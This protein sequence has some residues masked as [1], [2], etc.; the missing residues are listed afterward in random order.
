MNPMRLTISLI[1]FLCSLTLSFAAQA[2]DDVGGSV[3]FATFNIA[4]GLESEGE[5]YRRL[6]SGQDE[7]LK[8]VA[9]VIQQVRPD[10]LL[11]NEFDWYEL[12]SAVLF[13]NNYLS[14]PQFGNQAINYDHALNGAVN[15][16][17]DSGLDLNGNGTLGQPEDAWG[18]GK[19]SGQYG[20]M[21]LSRFPLQLQRS[22]RLFKWSD[23][24]DALIPLN[25]DGSNYYPEAIWKQLRLSSKNHW[26]IE[27]KI[28][29]Q[30]VHFLASHPTPPVFDG[31]EDRN[32]T[33]NHDEIRFWADYVDPQRSAYII[34]DSGISGG[35][36]DNT[37]FIIAGD[38]NA[39]PY[40]G[41]SSAKAI[42]QLLE[43]P[44]INASCEP[45]SEGAAEASRKQAG[46]N[47]AHQG[48]PAAD[49][50]DFNDRYTGNMRIDYVLPSATLKVSDCGVYWPALGQPGHDLT[51]VSDHHLVW[52][53]IQF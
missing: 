19:F 11:L 3:R 22:F 47:Q 13:I 25:P 44:K 16:G 23:M 36:P 46:K 4:M 50:G 45:V 2:T 26:D 27:V 42:D 15:T 38:L 7:S 29:D 51:D 14:T 10:V 6:H 12:D 33:R 41:D 20:M 39:D 32:G 31:P 21:V 52:L 53:D 28:D 35:L 18:Y 34:D 43:H 37:K 40:D 17:W 49:T 48:N 5:L 8:K 30:A 1:T 9:A 24:P